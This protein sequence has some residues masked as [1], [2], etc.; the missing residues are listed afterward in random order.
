MYTS[1]EVAAAMIRRLAGKEIHLTMEEL[2]A[3]KG[4][5]PM[6]EFHPNKIVYRVGTPEAW[7]E[8]PNLDM[9][10]GN[11]DP[12]NANLSKLLSEREPWN[13]FEVNGS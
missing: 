1:W 6:A 5:V 7:P 10:N 2:D 4:T 11:D 9:L 13:D 12:H 8:E 3:V